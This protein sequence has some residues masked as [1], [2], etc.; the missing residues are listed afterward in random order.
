MENK[1]SITACFVNLFFPKNCYKDSGEKEQTNF[2]CSLFL[3]KKE[4][5]FNVD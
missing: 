5:L 4:L 2:V 1:A 3:L